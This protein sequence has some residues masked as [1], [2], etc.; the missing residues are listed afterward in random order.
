MRRACAFLVAALVVAGCATSDTN[1]VRTQSLVAEGL[2]EDAI[3]EL[4]TA[5][6]DVDPN[7]RYR[8][9]LINTRAQA[10]VQLLR[11][12]EAY[13]VAGRFD[14]A[15]L[16][17]ER[18]LRMQPAEQ[19]AT[20]GLERIETERRH[21][22]LLDQAEAAIR[23]GDIVAAEPPLKRVLLEAPQSARALTLARRLEER[24]PRLVAP[25]LAASL[26][27]PITLEFRD[28][29]LK[30][31]FDVVSK[32]SGINFVLDKDIRADAKASIFVKNSTIEDAV[33]SLIA[34]NQLAK[35]TLN[36]N[37]VLIY[38]N[39]PQKLREY[40][41]LVVR[42]FFLSSAEA[43][44]MMNL[45]KTILKIRDVYIDEKR[46][47]LVI[48]DTPEAVLLADRLIQAHDQAEPEAMLE[49]EVIEVTRTKTSQL[50]LEFPQ[51][52]GFGVIDP[53]TLDALRNLNATGVNVTGL[54]PYL[55]INLKRIFGDTNLLA[56]PRI[57]VRNR[58]KAK[59]HVGDRVPIIS[60]TISSTTAFASQTVSYLDV[61]LKLEVE[62][63]VLNDDV[64]IKVNLEVSSLGEQVVVQGAIAYKVGTRNASTTLT[65]KDGET[66]ILAGLISDFDRETA[67]KLPGLGELPILGRLFSS[68]RS[69]TE[70]TEII[71]SITP[72]IL[73]KLERPDSALVEFSS[74]PETNV[75]SA[76]SSTPSASPSPAPAPPVPRGAPGALP[77]AVLAPAPG[78]VAVPQQPGTGAQIP[79]QA[80][81]FTGATPAIQ[82]PGTASAPPAQPAITPGPPIYF[83]PPP[84][85]GSQ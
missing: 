77:G 41:D 60:S 62:P 43:K 73:R 26:R 85:V 50:G 23:K 10:A 28:A 9:A 58:E 78:A 14:D 57:R 5:V 81:P 38:P 66:Q 76:L 2:W 25:A 56:N 19:R 49:V 29:N 52:I 82:A 11:N 72:R 44:Q 36:D 54:N 42:N 61:G 71:L 59:I 69:E 20:A 3:A 79:A 24:R 51:R 75:R 47:L 65:L 21:A 15:R 46:N 34:S 27:K 48:R 12:A 31:I 40:Q 30:M 18:L 64:V 35:K 8:A 17:L 80:A 22:V 7:H 84:G 68:N 1:L 39:T 70:K 32:A 4:E 6:R 83:K 13:R 16:S 53:I 45:L 33:E 63:Q 55:A 74:G 67:Q 37:S